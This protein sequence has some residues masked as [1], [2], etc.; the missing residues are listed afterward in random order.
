[1]S[2]SSR[3]REHQDTAQR[4]AAPL[5]CFRKGGEPYTR[6]QAVEDEIARALGM[7]HNVWCDQSWRL[8]TLVYLIRL[9]L[10]DNDPHIL[11]MLTYRFL[12]RVKPIVD[13][14]SRGYGTADSEE[15]QIA[16]ANELGD[17]LY[18]TS[19]TAE[20]LEI[21]AATVVK[22]ATLRATGR[23]RPKAGEF[24]SADRDEEGQ[25]TQTVD[26]LASEALNPLEQLLAKADEEA[27]GALRYLNAVADPRHRE[28][29]IL[30]HIYSWPLKDGQDGAPTLCERFKM[31]DRQIRNWIN[32]AIEQMRAAHGAES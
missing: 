17:L 15:I 3:D 7:S 1:M 13:R 2:Q 10:R 6:H 21:D 30:R 25:Y 23:D 4:R 18:K 8:E 5:R 16:V 31:S 27:G 26:G 22:Q 24:Q 32:T 28:A 20:Y 19:R 29:F 12:E 11:G 14:W 9:R